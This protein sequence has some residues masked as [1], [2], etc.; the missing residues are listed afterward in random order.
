MTDHK[1]TKRILNFWSFKMKH[2]VK[3]EIFAGFY[4]HETSPMQSIAKIRPS[5]NGEITLW[6][7]DE[8]KS[9][10]HGKYIF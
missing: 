8:G 6:F 4:F 1:C 5:R 3:L 7:T 2:N 9:C 10:P